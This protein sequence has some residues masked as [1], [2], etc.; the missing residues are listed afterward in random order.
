MV[1]Y[2]KAC[3]RGLS[4]LRLT[5]VLLGLS[6]VMIF[7]GTL[8]QVHLGIHAAQA[9]Y[10]RS[11]F[12]FWQ[13]AG[14]GWSIPVFPG[15][16]LIGPLLFMNLVAA[17]GMRF[18]LA[19]KKIGIFLIHAGVVVLLLGELFTGLFA[20]ESMMR[21]DIGTAQ[22]YSEAPRETELAVI[23][24]SSNEDDLV[25]AIPESLLARA[26]VIQHPALPFTLKIVK[27]MANTSL[28]MRSQAPNSPPSLATT[29]IGPN[30]VA[31]EIPRTV[32]QDERDLTTAFVQINTVQ[33]PLGTWLV[34]NALGAPQAFTYD[35]HT[36][37]LRMRQKR[38][39][40]PF[41]IKLLDFRHDIYP[42][43]DIPKNFSS[44]IRLIDSRQKEDRNVLIYMNSP[45]RYSGYTFY[46]AGFD[47]SD[48]TSIL[49]VV[50]NPTFLLPYIACGLVGAGLL[51]QFSMHLV[52]FL[53]RRRA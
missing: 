4:S 29:G 20:K 37:E 46:Q 19:A 25:V 38:Y 5:V 33:G 41:T 51:T 36:Y 47:N 27:F 3:G 30:V 15:G 26:T 43:T 48:K 44:R 42:G 9:K 50:K 52:G 11:L 31:K 40:K 23:D 2:L 14:A 13:P 1:R 21:M 28:A 16:Y 7:F 39:Y 6:M 18:K 17:H 24:T 8:D 34:S 12:V 53:R 45:L 32:K 35:G 49:Q 10:F 22:T